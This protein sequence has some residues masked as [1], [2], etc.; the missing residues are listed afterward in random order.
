[1]DEDPETYRKYVR[2][3][4]NA[5]NAENRENEAAR[6]AV[7][8]AEVH[9]SKKYECSDCEITLQSSEALEKHLK[10]R[11]HQDVVDG[12]LKG[13]ITKS[14]VAVKAVRAAAKANKTYWCSTC[15]KAFNND[16]SLTRHCEGVLHKRRIAHPGGKAN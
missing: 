16:W 11:A 1:M 15:S 12:E 13:P 14:A 6:S 5:R 4:K 2:D 8:R 9:A 10:S 3:S 7:N